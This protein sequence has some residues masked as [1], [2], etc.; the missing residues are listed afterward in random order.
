MFDYLFFSPPQHKPLHPGSSELS[1]RW[2]PSLQSSVRCLDSQ[3]L[4][5]MFFFSSTL[6]YSFVCSVLI[7]NRLSQSHCT[8]CCEGQRD[9]QDVAT[10]HWGLLLC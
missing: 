7:K 2:C 8:L 5:C 10:D 3:L 4:G 1:E 6:S 9:E